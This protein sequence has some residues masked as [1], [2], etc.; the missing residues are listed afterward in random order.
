MQPY[1]ISSPVPKVYYPRQ[2]DHENSEDHYEV[3]RNNWKAK[4]QNRKPL[5]VIQPIIPTVA[6]LKEVEEKEDP[7]SKE[8]I[9]TVVVIQVLCYAAP[10]IMGLILEYV[11]WYH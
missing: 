1:R 8:Y 4:Q 2:I 3:W 7:F 9:E 5:V 11:G 10:V 6:A